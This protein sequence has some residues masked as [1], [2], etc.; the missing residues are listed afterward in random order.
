LNVSRKK[1]E[2]Y[3]HTEKHSQ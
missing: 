3:H 2:H 1:E